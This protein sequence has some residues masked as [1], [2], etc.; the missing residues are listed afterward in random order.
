MKSTYKRLTETISSKG[1]V[2]VCVM[3][4]PVEVFPFLEKNKAVLNVELLPKNIARI[5]LKEDVENFILM[6]S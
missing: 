1:H 6:Q 2:D 5:S 3:S 4:C